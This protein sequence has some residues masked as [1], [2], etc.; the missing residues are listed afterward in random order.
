MGDPMR[1]VTFGQDH[2]HEINGVIFDKTCVAKVKGDRED[3]FKIFG[4]EFCM[5]YDRPEFIRLQFF[6]RGIIEVPEDK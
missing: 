6:P 5:E 2:V 1:Y 3:V 4:P